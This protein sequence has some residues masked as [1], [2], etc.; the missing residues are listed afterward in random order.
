MKRHRNESEGVAW[1]AR[2][3]WKMVVGRWTARSLEVKSRSRLTP[4][5]PGPAPPRVA[6]GF[7]GS[8]SP[9]MGAVMGGIESVGDF[10]QPGP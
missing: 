9:P 6:G 2:G 7:L 1:T 5:S 4:P 10:E 8:A 3:G